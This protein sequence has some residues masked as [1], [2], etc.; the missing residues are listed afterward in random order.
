M[1]SWLARDGIQE[2]REACGGHGYLRSARLGDLR[3]DHDPNNTYEGD[4]NVLLMQTS[5]YIIKLYEDKLRNGKNIKTQLG[6]C[7]Y[8]DKC[9]EILQDTQFKPN[10]NSIDDVIR[11]FEFMICFL[12]KIS[13]DKLRNFLDNQRMTQFES[14]EETQV[15]YLRNLS[16]IFFELNAINAFRSFINCNQPRKADQADDYAR[17]NHVLNKLLLLFSLWC[18]DKNFLVLNQADFTGFNAQFGLHRLQEKILTLCD[19]LKKECVALVDA[20]A[21]ADFIVNSTLGN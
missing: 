1:A 12:T 20:F 4:N 9:D 11:V 21:P 13:A 2:A 14:R 10:V 17:V 5:N 6:I 3:N 18:L 19:Q 16:K 8:L 15:Y 7:D